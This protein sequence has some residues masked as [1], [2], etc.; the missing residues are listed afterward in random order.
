M[1]YQL[2]LRTVDVSNTAIAQEDRRA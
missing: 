1:H 2:V